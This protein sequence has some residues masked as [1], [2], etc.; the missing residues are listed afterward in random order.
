MSPS[1]ATHFYGDPAIYRRVL[2]HVRPHRTHIAGAICL[3]L[4]AGPL[5]LLIP[6]PVQ[7]VVDSILGH[8]PVPPVLG[9]LLPAAISRSDTALL[10][11]SAGTF[12]VLGVLS[13]LQALS[14]TVLQTSTGEKLVLDLRTQLFNHV[15]KLSL[16]Y[17]DSKGTA[18][19]AYRIQNDAM[20]I[21]YVAVDTVVTFVTA[22]T[23]VGGMVLVIA[24]MDWQVGLVAMVITPA[25]YL[26]LK[27]YGRR[28]RTRA[29]EVK[30]L[31]SSALSVVQEGLATL[32]TVRAFGREEREEGRFARR[33]AD[34]MRARVRYTVTAGALGLG[35]GLTLTTGVAAVLFIGA[36]HVRSGTITLG[37]LVLVLAYLGQL[38]APLNVL[39]EK[40]GAL[41]DHLASVERVFHVLDEAPD[42]V[43]RSSALPVARASG[44]VVFEDVS[45]SYGD[46]APVLDGISFAIGP[47]T[48][49][50][51]VGTTGAGKSTLVSLL[52]RFY[53]PTAGRILLD[54]VDL[55]DYKLGDLRSQVSVV[56]QEPVLFS[57]SIA[58][59]IAYSRPRAGPEDVE[60]AAR[61]ANA[62]D[63]I[64]ALAAG[65]DTEVGERGTH[66]SGGERQRISLARA[67]LKDAPLL[68]LDEP[69]SSID[70]ST[71][72]AI[73]DAGE[74]LI[75]GRT[76][77]MIAHRL[78]TLDRCDARLQM[79]D[80]Q[81]RFR[82]SAGESPGRL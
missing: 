24:L 72:A 16:S 28:L 19:S 21:R 18:D 71:E 77:L 38:Y 27:G 8:Q 29:R 2:G 40:A 31:E 4:L 58:E 9:A 15:Q 76:T 1:S 66:L 78:S 41:Q 52:A 6:V 74:R 20:S 14:S 5:A 50:G 59:N 47:G 53:D 13:Q 26:L 63:F 55:R 54:G 25:L 51:I 3:S 49:L 7:I 64:I 37:E 69:T 70:L 42:V 81:I 36:Q 73:M 30:E 82:G 39:S 23:T 48:R 12:I 68:I 75:R 60:A 45:F 57:T 17:H 43:E 10:A 33:A 22:I 61:A 32:R 62:H 34:G 79:D 56:L 11:V 35:I 46:G 44:A 67:F 65:Y 80:G